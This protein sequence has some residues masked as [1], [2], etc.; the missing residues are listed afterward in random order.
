MVNPP[1]AHQTEALD[2]IAEKPGAM[3]AMDMG[4]GKSRV[5]V[6]LIARKGYQKVLI[7]APLSV[8]AG[9]WPGEFAKHAPGLLHVLP[10]VGQSTKKRQEVAAKA[11]SEETV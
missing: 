5:I 6:D 3:L 9:V 11:R 1:W 8:V 10:L 7:L 4:T 2:F